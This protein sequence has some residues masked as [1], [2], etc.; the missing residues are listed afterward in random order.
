[1]TI[2]VRTLVCL[3]AACV[4]V[5]AAAGTAAASVTGVVISEFRFRG[6]AGGNDEF[7]ELVNASAVPVNIGGWK[8][9]GCNTTGFVSTRAT[10]PAGTTLL[11]GEHYLFTNSAAAGYSGSVPGDTNY[12]TGVVDGGGVK[13]L[14]AG[15]AIVDAAGIT[16]AQ[17]ASCREGA[18]IASLG[19][20]NVDRSFGRVGGTQDTD[21]NAADFLSRTPSE[22][23]NW[24][25]N[26]LPPTTVTPIHAIQGDGD[27]S[28]LN[29]QRVTVEG[30]VTGV[31][32]EDGWSNTSNRAFPED[33]GIFVQEEA[34]DWDNDP[35]TSEGIFVGFVDSRM[36]LP[37]GTVVRIE[38][39]VNEKFGLTTIAEA[40]GREPVVVG[41]AGVPDPLSI[42]A[43]AAD[44]QS[45]ARPYYE[46]LEG[47]RVRL[48]SGVANSGGTNKFGE[49]FLTPGDQLDRVFRTDVER[50]L[51]ATDADAGAGDPRVPPRD[52]DGSTTEVHADLFDSVSN[53]VGPMVF[54]FENYRMMVQ[55]RSLPTVTKGPTPY[56][57][58][59]LGTLGPYQLRIA[60]FNVENFFPVGG[61][62]D[63]G[64]V[65]A[66]EYQEKKAKIADAIGRLLA[67]P[68]VVAVQEVVD[69]EIL[70][71]L[72]AELGGYTAYLEEG[73]DS[74]GIDV[75][76]LVKDTIAA[77]NVRQLGKTA[78]TT[79]TDCADGT[80]EGTPLLFD[81]PPLALDVT[82]GAASFTIVTNHF[83]SKSHP[84]ACR[85]EQAAFVR[86]FVDGVEAAGGNAIVSG[87][88]NAF[89]DESPL[90][91]LEDGQTTLTNL[92]SLAPAEER[93]SFAF[94]G[95]LQTLDHVLVTD[96]LD[97]RVE[98]FRYAH[99]DND[100]FERDSETDGHH[101]SDHDP[102]VLTLSTSACPGGDERATV[103]VGPT[104]TGVPNYDRG[105]GC[106][107]NDLI[108]ENGGY[109]N[110]G[111]WVAHVAHVTNDLVA[112]EVLTGVEKGRIDN[113]AARWQNR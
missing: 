91:V 112:A 107:V 80:V 12:S 61:D 2:R 70:G 64:T 53:V 73:N 85:N 37:L 28:P 105:D 25:K 44:A 46:S 29:G 26:P 54:A 89:E 88:L 81:R 95:R 86:N 40:F 8:L 18:G 14:T 15:A 32:D 41:F 48:A 56:P 43:A 30:I 3:A 76:Y 1:M 102:P 7:V 58:D 17:P 27:F 34:A 60:S 90:A 63:G 109:A 49:L 21:D 50:G 72:A 24:G 42:D 55:P 13:L 10:V 99:F 106:T 98:D 20:P 78:T 23:Q 82:A 69:A 38:G 79:R 84:D 101:V 35:G 68:D 71:A 33:A 45:A 31:D 19:T 97:V 94:Q 111:A 75:G 92:W 9:D 57:Y 110:Q 39:A 113:A 93:Y 4:S 83:A 36:S 108:V 52:P 16:T 6:P 96:A 5:L 66:D 59:E 62:L 104:N 65:T 100:Y 87:D 47:M 51:L 103:F 22:P 67:S 11:A 74:R 77:S